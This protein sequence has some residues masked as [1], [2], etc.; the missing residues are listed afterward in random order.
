M[1]FDD[2][3]RL[4]FAESE[5]SDDGVAR[6]ARRLRGADQ[7]DQF[8]QIVERFLETKQNVLAVARFA[9]FKIGAPPHYID[10]V[11]DEVPQRIHQAQLARLPVDDRQHDHAEADLQL[12]MLVQ[13]VED[14]L[15]LL[16]PFQLKHDA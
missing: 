16:A 9:Q 7:L 2:G 4:F 3:L 8:I 15:R 11:L 5:A 13:V 12:R 6:L 1:Q 10:T 14:N